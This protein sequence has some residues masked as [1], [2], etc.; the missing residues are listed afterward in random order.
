LVLARRR[1][2]FLAILW[3]AVATVLINALAPTG[4]PLTRSAGSAFN[5]FTSDVSLGPK[6]G[7]V[8]KKATSFASLS[9]EGGRGDDGSAVAATVATLASPFPLSP[10][11]RESRIPATAPVRSGLPASGR[12]R[13]RAPPLA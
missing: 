7:A 6:R 13:A 9:A 12:F 2:G 3:L 11:P 10:P 4:S 8:V 5:P 1:S